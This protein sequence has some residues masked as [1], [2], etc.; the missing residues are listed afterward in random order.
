MEGN[1]EA[2]TPYQWESSTSRFTRR[3]EREIYLKL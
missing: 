1:D 3:V 2:A